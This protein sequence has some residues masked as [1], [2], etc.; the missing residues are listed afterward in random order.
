MKK[1]LLCFLLSLIMCCPLVVYGGGTVVD[2]NKVFK[3]VSGSREYLDVVKWGGSVAVLTKDRHSI[4]YTL[5]GS[6]WTDINLELFEES[7]IAVT[8]D[9]VFTI[10]DIDVLGDQLIAGCDGGIVLIIT[11][12]IK[13]YKL[14][15]VCDFDIN[16]ISF[17]KNNMTV[18]GKIYGQK[19]DIPIDNIRQSKIAP[20]EVQNKLAQGGCLIDVRDSADYTAEHIDGAVNIPIDIIS[21]IDSYPRDAVLIFYCYGG[22]RA[23]KAV[24]AARD[25]GFLNVYNAGGY[26][27]LKALY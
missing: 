12:C 14:K 4:K 27:E 26:E 6:V 2:Q 16:K 18:Y 9:T 10:N 15:Q 20:S 23:G 22:T 1:R 13:C 17:D 7:D 21:K 25:M 5:L 11:D 19:A 8:E 3:I 24:E